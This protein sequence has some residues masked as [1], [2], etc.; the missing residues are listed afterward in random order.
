MNAM[1]KSILLYIIFACCA[2]GAQAQRMQSKAQPKAQTQ[3][4]AKVQTKVQPKAQILAPGLK[5]QDLVIER[6]E[7]TNMV[8]VAFRVIVDKKAAKSN[9]S[10]LVVPQLKDAKN[11]IDLPSIEIRGNKFNISEARRQMSGFE[12]IPEGNIMARNRE[13]FDYSASIPWAEWMENATEFRTQR[14]YC[15]CCNESN[16]EFFTVLSGLMLLPPPPPPP[17]APVVVPEP[18]VVEPEPVAP[19]KPIAPPPPPY[20]PTLTVSYM[21]PEVEEVKTRSEEVSAYLDFE[22][23]KHDILPHFRNNSFE[24][25]KIYRLIEELRSDP[26]ATV[27]GVTVKGYASPEASY[28]S[29]L[30][31]SERRAMALKYHLQSLYRF[32]ERVIMARGMGEDWTG[33]DSLV[34]NS[35]YMS[36][37]YRL[38]EII[39]SYEDPDRKEFRLKQV[40]RGVPYRQMLTEFYPMLRRS[41][42][43]VHYTVIPFTVQ[44]G[45][46]V[47]KTKPSSMSL[48][49]MFLLAQEYHPGEDEFNE[50]FATAVRLYPRNDVANIN[51]AAVALDNGEVPAAARYLSR[52]QDKT[53]AAYLNNMGIL[54]FL[55]DDED[56]AAQY[57]EQARAAGN[58]E[59]RRNANELR[60]RMEE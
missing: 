25:N 43:Q 38:L 19:P 60:K 24:L 34:A 51:A 44:M 50:I 54:S 13:S 39:R 56:L 52:V 57:F 29:N 12:P 27:T 49:E 41:D 30:Q 22:V 59:A 35:P 46:D 10:L 20:D 9:Y 21:V 5:Y 42:C 53:Q 17:P 58:A 6:N 23:A 55:Q 16:P 47:F 32:D 15:G 1:K 28:A 4:Q 11:V 45:R 33:L 8:D 36:D 7:A 14:S 40:A 3:T 18:V 31:L 26:Y 48:N 37:K 2:I